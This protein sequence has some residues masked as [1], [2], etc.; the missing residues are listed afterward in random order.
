[1]IFRNVQNLLLVSLT[2]D[3]LNH[4]VDG[5]HEL[6]LERIAVRKMYIHVRSGF[7]TIVNE[8]REKEKKIKK[9]RRNLFCQKFV[10]LIFLSFWVWRRREIGKSQSSR[11]K[12]LYLK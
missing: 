9:S 3:V 4:N 5:M 10:F 7:A 2:F 1:M 8:F 6:E 12:A 11:E